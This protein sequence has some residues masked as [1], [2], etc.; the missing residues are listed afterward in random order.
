[1]QLYEKYRPKVFGDVL[2]QS[3][4]VKQ[5][6]SVLKNGWGS[7]VFWLAGASGIGKTTL[8]K[9]V[10]RLGADDFFI[11]EYDSADALNMQAVDDIERAMHLYGG[12]KGGRVFLINEAHGLR[13]Q[14]IRRL[15]GLLERIPKH[16]IWIFTTTKIGQA[17][18]FE[19]QIDAEPLLSR[20]VYIEL[21]NQGLANIFAERAKQI[22]ESEN[23]NGKPL[24][25][26]INLA[27]SCHN[28]FRDI[29]QAVESGIML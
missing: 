11:N 20:C 23:L 16:V 27:K 22:A 17:G 6:E 15:L 25:A 21:T 28:N 14:I 29:L 8:G 4:V 10:A 5:I 26:Y 7:Q 3:K 18:L 24:N 12:G 9:I 19:E 2:G 13:K 1:M